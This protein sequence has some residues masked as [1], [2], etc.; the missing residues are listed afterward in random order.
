MQTRINHILNALIVFFFV[1]P[2][3]RLLFQYIRFLVAP[4]YFALYSIT[5]YTGIFKF[6]PV[7]AGAILLCVILKIIL[8]FIEKRK[9]TK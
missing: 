2:F 7:C 9:E 4:E 6:G 8:K 5:W 1:F 3:G